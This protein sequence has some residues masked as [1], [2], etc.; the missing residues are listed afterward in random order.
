[1]QTLFLVFALS[2]ADLPARPDDAVIVTRLVEAL[3]DSD[4]E[5]RQNLGAALAKLSA[6]AVGPLTAALKDPNPARRAGAAYALGLIGE[7]AAAALPGLLDALTDADLEVRRQASQS[8]GRVL[9]PARRRGPTAGPAV[10][11]VAGRGK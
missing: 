7:P 9:T 3:K 6:D 11:P 5:V 8:V 2:T 1:M 4:V 10:L